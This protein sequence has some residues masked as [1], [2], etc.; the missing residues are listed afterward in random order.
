MSL[1]THG[2]R[3][4]LQPLRMR[5]YLK[6]GPV[7]TEVIKV[8]GLRGGP[9]PIGLYPYRMGR[10]GPRHTQKDDHPPAKERCPRK[11]QPC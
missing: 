6:I 5:P 3:S 9:F 7:F 4:N 11:H 10:S 1:Q 2:R 8:N